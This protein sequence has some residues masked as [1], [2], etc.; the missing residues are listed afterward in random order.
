MF[1]PGPYTDSEAWPLP[2]K[3][4]EKEKQKGFC[5]VFGI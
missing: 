4:L 3:K 5:S 2:T 1:K